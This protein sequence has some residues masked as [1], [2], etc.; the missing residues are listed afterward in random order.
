MMNDFAAADL[1]CTGMFEATMQATINKLQTLRQIVWILT[2]MLFTKV[3]HFEFN[4]FLTKE[5]YRF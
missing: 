5:N 4:L 3:S 2:D 1:P